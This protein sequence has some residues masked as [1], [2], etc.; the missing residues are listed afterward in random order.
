MSTADSNP[1]PK[2]RWLQFS[3]RGLLLLMLVVAVPLGWA[4]D[5]V[6]HQRDAVSALE[7]MG[8]DVEYRWDTWPAPFCLLASFSSILR[9]A[10]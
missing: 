6:R 3:V 4:M 10:R 1:K 5:K 2:R 9:D 7:K 8:C